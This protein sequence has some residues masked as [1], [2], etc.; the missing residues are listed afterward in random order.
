[1]AM[2]LVDI[3]RINL[4]NALYHLNLGGYFGIWNNLGLYGGLKGGYP[5]FGLKLKLLFM[6]SY[7]TYTINEYS[8]FVGY[9]P[10]DTLSFS[11][12]LLF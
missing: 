8:E 10:K 4:N 6:E 2:D 12:R 3:T 9:N 5:S 7:V 11:F 1:L